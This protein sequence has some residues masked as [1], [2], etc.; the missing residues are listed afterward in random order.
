MKAA[1]VARKEAEKLRRFLM[2]AELID[3][4]YEAEADTNFVYFPLK[5]GRIH[6][7]SQKKLE[8]RFVSVERKFKKN[9]MRGE[10]KEAL[11]S[12]L[13]GKE[14]ALLNRSYDVVGSIAILD[15][16]SELKGRER[17]I[18]KT[19]LRLKNNIR[20]V[21][22][23]SGIHKG[24]FRT[25][26]LAYILGE[27]TKE[28]IHK[29]NDALIKLDVEKVYFSPRLSTERKRIAGLVRP[30]E[31][32]LVMFSGCGPYPLVI[33]KNTRAGRIMGIEKNKVAHEYALKNLEL[34]KIRNVDFV[35]GDVREIVP[36]LR[37]RFDMSEMHSISEHAQKHASGFSPAVF[38]RII[39][40]L[41]KEADT[42]LDT[43]FK[44]AKRGTVIHLYLFL[45]KDGFEAGKTKVREIA[46]ENNVRIKFLG[47]TKCG[48]YSPT[49]F[50]CCIDFVV[51]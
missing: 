21:L 47:L 23:K 38:D 4:D 8:N 40:P 10:L 19:L 31:N 28:T 22:N 5:A 2:K 42:F 36:R 18:A 3:F 25:Q 16:P 17:V 14:L 41:P 45:E 26:K 35:L 37:E 20:T 29:E 7:A 43:S 46:R 9:V 32:V 1:K 15:I 48:Q 12:E 11:S 51:L 30:G 34:N 44:V 39:M 33:A 13:S 24:E 6:K 50:R 49:T 27:R